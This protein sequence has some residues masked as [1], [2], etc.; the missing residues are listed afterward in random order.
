[1]ASKK[2]RKRR[3]S[4]FTVIGIILIIL[5]IL[6]A[7]A[8]TGLV[9]IK[10]YYGRSNYVRDDA[11]RVDVH[12]EEHAKQEAEAAG[13]EYVPDETLEDEAEEEY[14]RNV[15]N[16][17][18]QVLAE[19]ETE[20][21]KEAAEE[22]QTASTYN[23]L[24]IGS[25]RRFAGWNGN[26]DVMVLITVNSSKNTIYMTSFMR[27]LYA[28]I[29]GAGVRKLN[30]AYARSGGPLLVST[31]QSNY[32]VIIDNYAA[33]DFN[34]MAAII[35]MFGG[36]DVGLDAAEGGYIGVAPTGATTHLNGTQAVAYARIRYIG[37][38]DFER[39][40]RHREV[41]SSLLNR[42][43]AM[44]ISNWPGVAAGILPYIT[45][46][47]DEGRL[48]SVLSQIPGWMGYDLVQL[49]VPFD[50]HYTSVNEILIPDMDYTIRTLRG[51]L[52]STQ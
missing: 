9:L 15:A 48:A 45:H 6:G 32:G 19:E 18:A 44:G 26:S 40:A 52:Y 3:K 21:A 42:A 43:R 29:E 1:M 24:L 2:R 50:G 37:N 12:Y 10:Y 13:E 38:A 22:P 51:T 5:V 27:D 23:L 14:I 49:R 30:S 46:N 7:L 36:V 41:L 28:N 20:A 34:N 8:A 4:K 17:L 35:D 25:D 47:M 33:V 16:V 11:V 31:L 39:T